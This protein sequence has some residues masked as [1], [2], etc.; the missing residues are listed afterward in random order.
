MPHAS[1]STHLMCRS[2]EVA[3]FGKGLVAESQ[4]LSSCVLAVCRNN[5][6][7]R[8]LARHLTV[9]LLSDEQPIK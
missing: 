1:P 2:A 5:P 6:E 3:L 7:A 9:R 4:P 8:V